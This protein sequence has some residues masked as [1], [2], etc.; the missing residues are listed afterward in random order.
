MSARTAPTGIETSSESPLKAL[1]IGET[2]RAC[3]VTTRTSA[4]DTRPTCSLRA[5]SVTRVNASTR[6]PTSHREAALLA[7]PHDLSSADAGDNC[8]T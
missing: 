7:T 3:G 2:A 8:V 6:R 1:R 5:A 4:T